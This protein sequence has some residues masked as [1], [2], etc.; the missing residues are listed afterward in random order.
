MN[1]SMLMFQM[2]VVI[3]TPRCST[4]TGR[5]PKIFILTA[6]PSLKNKRNIHLSYSLKVG[7]EHTKYSNELLI[8]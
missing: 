5:F 3:L 1:D 7:R 8:I 2:H 4:M 6:L